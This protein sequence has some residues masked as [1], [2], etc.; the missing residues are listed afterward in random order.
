MCG[1]VTQ[2]SGLNIQVLYPT[3]TSVPISIKVVVI[4]AGACVTSIR[5]MAVVVATSIVT[6]TLIDV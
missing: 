3:F 4:I 5:V 2:Y 6:E 1:C